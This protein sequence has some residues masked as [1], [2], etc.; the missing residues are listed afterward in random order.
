MCLLSCYNHVIVWFGTTIKKNS[1]T[2]TTA[3]THTHT[4][5]QTYKHTHTHFCVHFPRF[6]RHRKLPSS[7]ASSAFQYMT[8]WSM[9]SI[10]YGDEQLILNKL[11]SYCLTDICFYN[12]NNNF[13]Q[14][15]VSIT[16]YGGFPVMFCYLGG[17]VVL[18]HNNP[19]HE[20]G[21]NGSFLCNHF[22]WS[23]QLGLYCLTGICFY[24]NNNNN[25]QD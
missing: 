14:V 3:H 23:F 12:N 19:K 16:H 20:V 11:R 18:L 24:N 13:E 9:H 4:H 17:L 22:P 5:T 15:Y 21:F 7:L 10:T 1:T 25:I 2:T 6:F 8:R